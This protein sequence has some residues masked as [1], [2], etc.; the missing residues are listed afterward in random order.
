[1]VEYFIT[2]CFMVG[3]RMNTLF[4]KV[5]MNLT[6]LSSMAHRCLSYDFCHESIPKITGVI[7]I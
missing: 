6:M 7:F 4:V 3:V 5:I 2:I 1:M